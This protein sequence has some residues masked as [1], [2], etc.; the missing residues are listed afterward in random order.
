MNEE[1]VAFAGV[2]EETVDNGVFIAIIN[3]EKE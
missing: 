2:T 1:T 3:A